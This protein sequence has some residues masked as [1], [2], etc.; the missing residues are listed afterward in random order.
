MSRPYVIALVGR[1]NVGK[2]SLFNALLGFRRTIVLDQPGTTMDIVRERLRGAEIAIELIDSQGIFD[3]GD[4]SVVRKLAAQ[5]DAFLFVVDASTGPTPFDRWIANL[6]LVVKKP[7]LM[8]VNKQDARGAAPATEFAELGFDNAVE[9]SVSHRR[10]MDSVRGWCVDR[11]RKAGIE[12]WVE[13]ASPI[14][15][16]LVGRPNTGKSTLMNRLC[17]AELSRVS[18]IPHTTRDTIGHVVQL[19][20]GKIALVDTAG[21][22]R[23]RSKKEDLEI[24][25]IQAS[26]RA[27]AAAEVVLLVINASEPVADQDVRLLNLV[28]REGKPT[29]VLLNFWDLLSRDERK[30]FFENSDFGHLLSQFKTLAVSAKEGLNADQIFPMAF[31]LAKQAKK[32]V[33]TSRLNQIVE[34]MVARNPPPSLGRHNFNILYASQVRTEPPSFVF[35]LNRKGA[36][37]PSY[38]KYLENG[39]RQA[40]G[41]KSQPIRLF[42]RGAKEPRQ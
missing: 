13:E 12:A 6:L 7:V 32:R 1:P 23:P 22:R 15:V 27:L 30:H 36:L 26:T 42:F 9:I 3:E 34:R 17:G 31:R 11:A 40:L 39:L 5:A 2:S 16:A 37:P 29:V 21:V 20:Q 25:S 38:Q 8:C 41:Y 28:E 19:P 4:A 35:F 10:Q 18:P 14:K 24:F 33:K